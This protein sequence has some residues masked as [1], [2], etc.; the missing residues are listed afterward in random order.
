V[1]PPIEYIPH[2]DLVELCHQPVDVPHVD[3]DQRI[4]IR[5]LQVDAFH[6]GPLLRHDVGKIAL[7]VSNVVVELTVLAQLKVQRVKAAA[8][9]DHLRGD[10][11]RSPRRLGSSQEVHQERSHHHVPGVVPTIASQ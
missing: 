6:D 7:H 8:E 3:A 2:P 5:G 1:A 4:P 9:D 11:S 10:S